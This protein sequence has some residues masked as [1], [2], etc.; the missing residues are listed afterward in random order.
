M[1]AGND[2][3]AGGSARYHVNDM[4]IDENNNNTFQ[5][6]EVPADEGKPSSAS[7]HANAQDGNEDML[8][9]TE[10]DEFQAH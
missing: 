1:N 5:P 3:Y 4:D 2:A 8:D 9:E 10:H 6:D 7:Q